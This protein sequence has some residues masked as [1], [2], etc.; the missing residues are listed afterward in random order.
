MGKNKIIYNYHP[1]TKIFMGETFARPNPLEKGKWL[2]PKY[3]TEIKPPSVSQEEVA[4]FNEE[5]QQWY[6]EKNHIGE[7]VYDKKTK[8]PFEI[9]FPG[10]IP[11]RYTDKYPPDDDFVWNEQ[12]NDWVPDIKTISQNHIEFLKIQKE[13]L[14]NDILVFNDKNVFE[15]NMDFRFKLVGFLALNSA[16]SKKKLTLFEVSG[17]KVEFTTSEIK[18]LLRK[19]LERDEKIEEEFYRLSE[20]TFKQRKPEEIAKL[21]FESGEH[22]G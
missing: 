15:I 17:R 5:N 22:Y 8:E 16:S 19:I 11:E 21:T 7:I 9:G 2:I 12:Q 14:K 13:N 18:E 20:E 4:V 1:E 10:S 6:T 3:A